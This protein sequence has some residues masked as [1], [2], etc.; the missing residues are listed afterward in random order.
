MSS[1]VK[2][3]VI[4]YGMGKHHAYLMTEAGID[5]V[6][7]CEPDPSRREQAKIDYPQIRTY[8][9]VDELL[10]QPDINLVVVVTPHNTH[11]DLI[12]QV[13]ESGKNCVVDKP[14]VIHASDAW[15]LIDLA[16]Q[17]GVMLSIHHNRRWDAWY[18]TAQHIIQQGLLGDIFSAECDFSGFGHPGTTWR[19][20]KEASGG[21]FYDWGAHYMDWMLGIIPGKMKSIR[22]YAQKR[23]WHDYSNEDHLDVMIQFESG[24]VVHAQSSNIAY[25][26][27]HSFRILGTKG[28]IVCTKGEGP[29]EE[30][31]IRLYSEIDGVLVETQVPFLYPYGE[32]ARDANWRKFY[33]N[34]LDHLTNG[35]ELIVKPEQVA[36]VIA[37]LETA[38]KSAEEGL[39]LPVPFEN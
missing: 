10:A 11:A 21:A 14:F 22:G 5:F 26:P 15:A 18:V 6:A 3:A 12:R 32:K 29:E 31:I 30:R 24:A 33:D 9:S 39:E 38:T 4:G 28:A 20:F 37:V 17:K 23:M 35:A 27:K 25:A 7:V 19:S 16:K 1:T 8:A 13:L 2:S 34:I 36:R